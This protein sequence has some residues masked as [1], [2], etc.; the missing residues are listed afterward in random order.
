[1]CHDDANVDC[2]HAQCHVGSLHA[3]Q[4]SC[5]RCAALKPDMMARKAELSGF[6]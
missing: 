3:G 6:Q 4:S 2:F 1:M 5:Y